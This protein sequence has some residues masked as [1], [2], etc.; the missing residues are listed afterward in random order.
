MSI[1]WPGRFG[2]PSELVE[3]LCDELPA[4]RFAEELSTPK[5]YGS[6]QSL[7]RANAG[8]SSPRWPSCAMAMVSRRLVDPSGATMF[9][10][11]PYSSVAERSVP[12]NSTVRTAGSG[13]DQLALISHENSGG[14][15]GVIVSG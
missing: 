5:R 12:A 11:A 9:D 8:T 1:A 7:D 2:S 3:Q 10:V 6:G 15:V 14:G 13:S 4:E